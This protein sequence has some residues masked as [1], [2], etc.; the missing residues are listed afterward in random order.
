LNIETVLDS[1]LKKVSNI[2]ENKLSPIFWDYFVILAFFHSQHQK[3]SKKSRHTL[4]KTYLSKAKQY[5]IDNNLHFD[6]ET[7]YSAIE[8]NIIGLHD[9]A[10]KNCIQAK[11]QTSKYALPLH[12]INLFYSAEHIISV[13]SETQ[14]R[15]SFEISKHPDKQRCIITSCDQVYFDKYIDLFLSKST[16]NAVH[17]HLHCINFCP[18]N[19]LIEILEHKYCTSISLTCER[20]EASKLGDAFGTWCATSRFWI[21]A[22]ILKHYDQCIVSD[23]DGFIDTLQIPENLEAGIY[24]FTPNNDEAIRLPWNNVYAGNMIF[25]RD[26][27]ITEIVEKIACFAYNQLAN[28]INLLPRVHYFDQTMLLSICQAYSVT[29]QHINMFFNQKPIINFAL[30]KSR[31]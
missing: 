23:I 29:I 31:L 3:L 25:V 8:N 30:E 17:V 9:T 10:V 13:I 11:A 1:I 26:N 16:I 7:V 27:K 19:S 20:Y 4:F 2:D 12:P 24:T 6:H 22:A 15:P 18:D 5:H 21:L 14:K 28:E